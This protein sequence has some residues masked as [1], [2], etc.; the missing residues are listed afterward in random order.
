MPVSG[1][2]EK[3]PS[4]VGPPVQPVELLLWAESANPVIAS[5]NSPLVSVI[6][7]VYNGMATLEGAVRSV[8][9]QTL[10]DWELLVVDDCS[11]D[12]SWEAGL[13]LQ[14]AA[15]PD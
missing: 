3:D 14:H 12:G 13:G 10:A 15:Q 4:P 5:E 2:F 7:P 11:T 9:A 6:M 1:D 8:Q